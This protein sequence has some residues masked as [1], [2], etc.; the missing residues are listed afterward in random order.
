M[1]KHAFWILTAT[2]VAMLAIAWCT[3]N[4]AIACVA[5]FL[6]FMQLVDLLEGRWYQ[7]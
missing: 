4:G 5:A 1:A 2:N 3:S 7:P 6:V